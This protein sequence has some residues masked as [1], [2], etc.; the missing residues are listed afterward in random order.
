MK[1]LLIAGIVYILIVIVVCL[2]VVY[3]TRSTT[4]TMAYILL[5]IF[6]PIAG[7]LFYLIFGINYWKRKQYDKKSDEDE[8]V[9]QSL[10]KDMG[11]FVDEIVEPGEMN[12][13]DYKELASML[14]KVLRSPLTAGNKVKIFVN[15]EEKF[16]EVLQALRDAKHHIHLEYYIY[17]QDHIGKEIENILIE[18]AKQGVQVR[19]IYDD[20]GSPAINKK[21]EARLHNAGV[22]IHPFQKILFYLLA[23][24]LNYRNHR[25]IIVIDGQTAFTGGINVSDKY[26]N[27]K[28]DQLFWRDTHVRIDG[29]GV[30]YLQFLFIT[31]WNFCTAKKMKIDKLHFLTTAKFKENAFTQV[32]ASGPDSSQ[33]SILY[34]MLQAIY[35][36]KKEI[37]I[38]TPYFI[39]GESI[40]EALGIA[41]LSG[42]SVKLL[43]P[44]KGD[45][46]L[47]NSAAKSYYEKLL[48]A[49]VEIYRYQKGFVHAKT[50][51][52]DGK[53]SIIGTAN[54]DFRSFE[55]NFEVNVII[56]DDKV[57]NILRNIFFEDLK[58]AT[59]INAKEWC[60]RSVVTQ[61]PEKMA[62]LFSPVL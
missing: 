51:V 5:C 13:D 2:R 54:T 50:L 39:P 15:G 21:M 55:L 12:D 35:L 44:G 31:D 3:D 57:S 22:E 45:S 46:I 62:R 8:K 49:G 58:D 28:R 10:K 16:P 30:F 19:F 59:K 17:E 34:S 27:D 14:V 26:I 18:K 37:F 56:Y 32:V 38:T 1:W 29:P 53:L 11:V 43:V 20:F 25:K 52:A 40:L 9:L 23:N 6:I 48:V 24:R 7:V 41:A 47:V 61:L 42:I 4:K 60:N 36:A 33:P